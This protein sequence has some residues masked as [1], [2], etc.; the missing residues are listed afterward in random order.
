M[1]LESLS[2]SS[3]VSLLDDSLIN[4]NLGEFL[5]QVQ[6]GLAQGSSKSGL[7]YPKGSLLLSSNKKEVHRYKQLKFQ[8]IDNCHIFAMCTTYS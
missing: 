2:K 8:C 6:G 1:V 3:L 4:Q 5:N 7:L